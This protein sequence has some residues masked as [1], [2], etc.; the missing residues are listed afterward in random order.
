VAAKANVRVERMLLMSSLL[1]VSVRRVRVAH[2]DTWLTAGLHSRVT[3]VMSVT[4]YTWS[5]SRG[6]TPAPIPAV[7]FT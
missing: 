2:R 4:K 1:R 7:I 5:F 6:V 3:R